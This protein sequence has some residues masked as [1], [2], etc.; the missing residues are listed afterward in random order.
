M[1]KKYELILTE[2][3]IDNILNALDFYARISCGQLQELRNINN[4]DA[5]DEVLTKLQKEMFP[6]LNGLNNSYSIAGKD[7]SEGVKI[8]YDVYKKIMFVYN[9]VGVYSY[10]PYAIS[11]EGL[12]EFREVEIMQ[13]IYS[14]I[15]M[16]VDKIRESINFNNSHNNK[17]MAVSECIKLL[18]LAYNLGREKRC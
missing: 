16:N 3:Q 18:D 9:P 8:C 2:E 12:P 17:T 13:K 10:E 7:V 5:T 4:N 11:K 14:P 1:K 15:W 6:K